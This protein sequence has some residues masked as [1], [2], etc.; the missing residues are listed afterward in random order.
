MRIQMLFWAVT[1]QGG[2]ARPILKSC[3]PSGW[4]NSSQFLRISSLVNAL[5]ALV[6]SM[7]MPSAS[8]LVCPSVRVTLS[9]CL[10]NVV[11]MISTRNAWQRMAS[12]CLCLT[13]HAGKTTRRHWREPT[14]TSVRVWAGQKRDS[15]N[16]RREKA[17]R[18]ATKDTLGV[19]FWLGSWND[20][21]LRARELFKVTLDICQLETLQKKSV[22]LIETR[23]RGGK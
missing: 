20:H 14:R 17:N 8:S 19:G 18:M 21:L 15:G 11:S 2:M 6:I 10:Y 1:T 13:R 9:G 3:L 22:L 4:P 12:R 5:Y 16:T 23:A 7:K